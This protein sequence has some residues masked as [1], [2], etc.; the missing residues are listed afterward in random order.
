M[1]INDFIKHECL[2]KHLLFIDYVGYVKQKWPT[3]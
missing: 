1:T 3:L 2:T